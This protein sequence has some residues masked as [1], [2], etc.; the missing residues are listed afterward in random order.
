MPGSRY[1]FLIFIASAL[2]TIKATADDAVPWNLA[3]FDADAATLN[4]A[5]AGVSPKAGTDVVVLD[6]ENSYVFDAEGRAVHTHYLVYKV[7]T[8]RGAEGWDSID[9][10]WK[11]W[12]EDKPTMRARVVTPDNAVH[13]LDPKT[14][15]DAPA[16]D[17]DDKTYGDGRVLRAPLP[18]IA[19]GSVVEEEEVLKENAAFFGAGVVVRDYFGRRVPVQNSKL[20]LDAPDSLSLRYVPR[21]LPEVKPQKAE[22][23]GRIRV[24]FEMGPMEALDEIESYLPKEIAAQPEVAFSTGTSWQAIADGYGRVVDEKASQKDVQ[25]LVNG[26]ISGKTSRDEKAGAIVRF[27]SR[28]IRYT[29]VEFGD[30]A[31]IPHPPAETLKHKYG[32]CKDKA[33]LAVA[34]LRAAGIPAYVA[35]LNVGN[36]QDVE[37]ELPGMGLFDHAIVYVPGNPDLWIDPTDE[38]ARLGQ[39]PRSD[40]GRLSLVA[41]DRSTGLATI[42][43]ASSESNKI[44]EKREFYLAENGPARVIEIT[45]PHGIF[46]SEFRS[47]YADAD[48][49]D[50]K[51]NL[52]NYIKEQYL[53]DKLTRIERSDPAELSKQF[54]LEIEVGDAKRGFTDLESAV[55][56]IRLESLFYKLPGELQEREKEARKNSDEGL[57]KPK[58]SRTTDFQLPAAYVYEWQYKIVPPLGFQAKPLP[59]NA[60]LSLG[61]AKLTEEFALQSD[62]SVQAIV[63]F[64]TVKRRLTVSEAQELKQ[65]VVQLREGQAILVYFEPTTQ[66]L[67]D[68]GKMLEAFQ[69]SRD[70]IARHPKEA[71]HHLQR[72]KLLLAAGMGTAAREEARTAVKLEPTSALAQK[73]LAEVLEYDLVGRQFRRGSDY[74]GA[75]TAFREAKRLDPEDKEIVG[76]LA[77]LL[78]YNRDGER[79]GPGDKIKEA[80]AEYQTL[81]EE[82]LAKIGLKNNPAFALFYAGDF[83]AAKKS[84]ENVN[85]QLNGVIVASETALNGA[86]AGMTEARKRTGN[87]KDLKLVLKTAGEMLM[88]ARKYPAAAELMVA[89]ASGDNASNTMALAAMLQKAQIHEEMKLADSPSGVVVKMFLNISDAEITLEKMSA[90]YSRNAKKVMHDSDPEELKKTLSAGQTMR[91]GMKRTGFPADIMIDVVLSAMQEQVEGDD[92]SG[93]RVTLRAPGSNKITMWVIREDGQYKILDGAE[94]P[95][96]IGLEILERLEAGN[97]AGAR[98]LLDWV[99]DEEH[100]AGGDDPLAGFA[101]P[102]MWTKGKEADTEQM[103]YAAAAILAQT[104]PT[105]RDAIKILEAGRNAAKTDAEKV[106]LDV[107]LLTAYSNLEEYEK[108]Y[109]LASELAK[110][111]P[112]SKRLFADEEIALRALQRFAEADAVAQEM[113]KR[114]PEDPDVRRAFIYTAV[115]REDYATAH[116]LGHKLIEEGKAEGWDMNG[117]AW[118]ALFTGK[119]GQEDLDAATKGAQLTQNNPGALHTLGCVYAEMGKTKE[120]REVLVQAMD[121]LGLDELDANYWYAFGRIAE[122]YGE[123]EAATSDYKQAKKPNRMAQIPGSS[124]ALAQKRLVTMRSSK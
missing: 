34:M 56:A 75:E 113:T 40:Q 38:Y 14:I 1:P 46:E 47:I 37:S 2:F 89:G 65:K 11:P 9:V 79:D 17:E 92:N 108:S 33:T 73:T 120:A 61:P 69:V 99:R 51:R 21:M 24:V 112:E 39:I 110:Q 16:R 44:V 6:E 119:V 116:A 26:L 27:L 20:V 72:A 5:A 12:H 10:E 81:K 28:E 83:A 4:Q 86:A 58:K 70:F 88:R 114:L 45:E 25:S 115:A 19:P 98:V 100:L 7:M 76:N 35:L 87:E 82:E 63:R 96:A 23:N 94:K 42:P 30:A 29:G 77:I 15:S 62:G 102:R 8:Q 107:A 74:A 36:R 80:V 93:Y 59:P 105:A 91:N 71:V 66:V 68:Q 85:P 48:N 118:N 57:V 78:E 64:D 101:F 97:Q 43:E 84:A 121:L 111:Y 52:Q 106:N 124:Y 103:K 18:A 31:V 67:M 55:A 123:M 13:P 53:A 60:T 22:A 117:F 3:R 54:A 122:Q 95:N 50:N 41:R 104:K 49:N 90:I 32:D 109:G